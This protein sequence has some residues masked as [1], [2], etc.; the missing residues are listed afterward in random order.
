ME[1]IMT[2]FE[3]LC[4]DFCKPEVRLCHGLGPMSGPPLLRT[5]DYLEHPM[6]AGGRCATLTL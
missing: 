6:D 2:F 4:E 1:A 5:A 3:G